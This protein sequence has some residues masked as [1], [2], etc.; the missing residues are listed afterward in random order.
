LSLL[1]ASN[2]TFNS[3][4]FFVIACLQVHIVKEDEPEDAWFK[5]ALVEDAVGGLSLQHLA[6]HI[7]RG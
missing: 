3:S 6:S 1:C 4:S 7:V 2:L 5:N